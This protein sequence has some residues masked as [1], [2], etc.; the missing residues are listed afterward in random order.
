MNLW[1][2]VVEG[3]NYATRIEK[4][5]TPDLL[6]WFDTTIMEF[7]EKFDRYRFHKGPLIDL[8]ELLMILNDLHDELGRRDSARN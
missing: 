7:G 1:K 3:A 5:D 4:L 6:N 2:R 8:S